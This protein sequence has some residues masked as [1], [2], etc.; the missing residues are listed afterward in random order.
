MNG[1]E[2]LKEKCPECE[3]ENY[4]IS[5]M[6]KAIMHQVTNGE[7]IPVKWFNAYNALIQ[8]KEIRLREFANGVKNET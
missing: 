4:L 6:S 7:E 1:A 5:E 3:A 2:Y 8:K